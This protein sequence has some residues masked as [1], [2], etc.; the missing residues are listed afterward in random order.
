MGVLGG[1]LLGGGV[2][3]AKLPDGYWLAF[4]AAAEQFVYN[5]LLGGILMRLCERLAL[6]YVQRSLS[7]ILA[8]VVPGFINVSGTY[9]MHCFDA[10]EVNPIWATVPSMIFAPMGYIWWGRRKRNQWEK[11]NASS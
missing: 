5:F 1:L 11:A 6:K 2:F 7:L 8:L 3:I 10:G 9:V 4:T